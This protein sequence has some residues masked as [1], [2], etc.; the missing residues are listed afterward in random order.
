M[1]LK[2][3]R[4]KELFEQKERRKDEVISAAVEVFKEKGIENSKMTDIAEKAEVGVASVYRYFKTKPDLAVEVA[5]KFWDMEIN[6]IYTEF[7]KDNINNLIGI[8]KLKTIL[9]VF[10]NLYNN[11][12]DF[13]RFLEE[14]DNYVIKEQIPSEKLENYEKSIINLKNIIFEALEEGK[15]D[16]SI[17][18]DIDNE[19]FYI[20][21][22][23]SLMTLAQKLI[24]RGNILKSDSDVSGESQINLIIDMAVNYIQN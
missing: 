18:S 6:S 2:T 3:K 14:F 12:K 21:V 17:R 20:T 23:H 1:D 16:G 24:L 9:N 19:V 22:S 15:V 4:K 11:H 13:V 5:I 7:D 10:V 8:E